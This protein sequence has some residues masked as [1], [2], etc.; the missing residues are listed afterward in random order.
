[1][2]CA[3]AA[4]QACAARPVLAYHRD[5]LA[6]F[7]R[8]GGA[9]DAGRHGS[10]RIG[11]AATVAVRPAAAVDPEPEQPAGQPCAGQLARRVGAGEHGAVHDTGGGAA[12]RA[13]AGG[14]DA[15]RVGAADGAAQ[16]AG[17]QP[18]EEDELLLPEEH[19][20]EELETALAV[21]EDAG[22]SYYF[23]RARKAGPRSDVY[24]AARVGDLERAR[25]GPHASSMAEELM[26]CT[27]EC[28]EQSW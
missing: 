5:L 25:C 18:A 28:A 22:I 8:G 7:R 14:N 23:V 19:E 3:N 12:G 13:A 2:G 16:H 6:H 17:Q 26:A 21:P 24:A 9:R 27:L 20:A 1:M 10:A 15:A 4:A 11:C